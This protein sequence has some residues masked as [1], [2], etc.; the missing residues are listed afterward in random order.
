MKHAVL[1]I[2]LALALLSGT[3]YSQAPAIDWQRS[4]GGSGDETAFTLLQ[5]R[6]GGYLVAG[7]SKSNDGQVGFN[8]GGTDAWIVKLNSSGDTV[9]QRSLGGSSSDLLFAALETADGY[10]LAGLT[11]SNDGDVSG[12]HGSLDCWVVKLNTAGVLQWQK[13]YGGSS[14]DYAVALQQSNPDGIIER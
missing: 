6:D 1:L 11:A 12:N 10:V 5:T 3:G 14:I 2:V 4:F 7:Q 9:W 8:H 13:S